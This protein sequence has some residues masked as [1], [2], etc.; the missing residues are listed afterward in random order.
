M[1]RVNCIVEPHYP[2]KT[3]L[4]KTTVT[5]VLDLLKVKGNTEV[6]V[7]IVGDRKMRTLNRQFAETDATT[8]VLS[9]SQTEQ[10][11]GSSGFLVNPE[12][13]YLDLGDIVISYPQT[14][15]NAIKDEVLVD[16]SVQ[17]LLI[18]GILHLLGY[19]HATPADKMMMDKFQEQI[20]KEVA[21]QE[22]S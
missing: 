17:K 4:I 6:T 8:D 7:S 16:Q 20:Y 18:H 2:V 12:D 21:L 14:I 5:K 13:S 10:L 1:F 19:D 3:K 15:N 22:Q 11:I 9:F